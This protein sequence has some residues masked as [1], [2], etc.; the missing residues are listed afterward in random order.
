MRVR[1]ALAGTS[2]EVSQS[3]MRLIDSLAETVDETY[4]KISSEAHRTGE[5]LKSQIGAYLILSEAV[6]LNLLV[7]R[8]GFVQD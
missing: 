5:P 3:T 7:Q 6:I 1:Y 4:A 2:S 8:N